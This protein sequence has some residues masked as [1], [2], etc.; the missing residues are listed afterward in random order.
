MSHS[1]TTKRGRSLYVEKWNPAAKKFIQA[2][3]VCGAQGYHPGIDDDGFVCNGAGEISDFEH[4]AIRSELNR[5]F[6]PL[7]L[8]A[9]GRCAE[10]AKRMDKG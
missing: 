5:V 6:K 9:L 2:C 7:A 8:D 4:R 10:C 3:A 1:K